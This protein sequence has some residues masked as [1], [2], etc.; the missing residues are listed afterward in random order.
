MDTDGE[1]VVREVL[2]GPYP[3]SAVMFKNMAHHLRGLDLAFLD[4]LSHVLLTRDPLEMLPSLAQKLPQP[5]LRDTGLLEQRELLERVLAAGGTP[6]VIDA[7]TLLQN[8]ERV[9]REVCRRLELPFDPAMLS[10]PTG[11]KPE[12][13]VWAKHWYARVHRSSGFAPYT[14]KTTPL[15]EHL[16]PLLSACVPLYEALVPYAV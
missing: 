12:D 2:L 7:K 8:P 13:G 5:T 10:W 6:V 9:L 11:P 16:K 14:P 15:P 1:R 4:N 3:T